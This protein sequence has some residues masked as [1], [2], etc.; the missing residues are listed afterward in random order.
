MIDF[1]NGSRSGRQYV[2]S[3]YFTFRSN[4]F[5]LFFFMLEG[6]KIK[7]TGDPAWSGND[8]RALC[9]VNIAIF[10]LYLSVYIYVSVCARP[11]M[12]LR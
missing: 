11:N 1:L 2:V 10:K 4:T 8:P 9:C 12:L 5:C 3:T 6:G 7:N